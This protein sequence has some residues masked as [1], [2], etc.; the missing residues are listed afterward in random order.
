MTKQEDG[1]KLFQYSFL[2]RPWHDF[3]LIKGETIEFIFKLK[4]QPLNFLSQTKADVDF[5]RKSSLQL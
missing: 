1:N 2:T 5:F 3:T 4:K